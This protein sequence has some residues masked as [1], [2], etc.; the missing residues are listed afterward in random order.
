MRVLFEEFILELCHNWKLNQTKREIKLYFLRNSW[1]LSLC[2][3]PLLSLLLD[4]MK[5][6]STEA[7]NQSWN[8]SCKSS[9]G[10]YL[11]FK[12]T[13]ICLIHVTCCLSAS[14]AHYRGMMSR[15]CHT[16]WLMSRAWTH[17]TDW[18]RPGE[19]RD[20]GA[21]HPAQTPRIERREWRV[22]GTLRENTGE[23]LRRK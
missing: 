14:W 22:T 16:L 11:I 5:L 6:I 12:D 1:L 17:N 10:R 20:T 8:G 2:M 3:S 7:A 13:L 18:H 15:C 23:S 9:A 4:F 21:G 19:R